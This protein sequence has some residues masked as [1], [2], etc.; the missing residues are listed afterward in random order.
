MENLV[1]YVAGSAK[2]H[3]G[4]TLPL[5]EYHYYD[6]CPYYFSSR[7]TDLSLIDKIDIAKKMGMRQ[8]E[9]M[10]DLA[11]LDRMAAHF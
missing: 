4:D 5:L 8:D 11:E 6:I 1:T 9:V 3:P 7:F 2:R 10:D